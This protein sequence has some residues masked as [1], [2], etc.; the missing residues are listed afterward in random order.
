MPSFP[1]CAWECFFR[2][3]CIPTLS[4]GTRV[5]QVKSAKSLENPE[6]PANRLTD[7][8][9]QRVK[10]DYEVLIKKA[11]LECPEPLPVP[12]QVKKRGRPKRTKSRNLLIR[13]DV[14][15]EDVLRFAE[16]E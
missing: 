15:R 7:K 2:W 9:F 10:L 8:Q 16:N 11:H 1:R 6:N 3:V 4:V 14:Y 12:N 13:L 5:N